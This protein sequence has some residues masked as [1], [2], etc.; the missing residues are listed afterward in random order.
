MKIFAL[1]PLFLV[2]S[3]QESL[4]GRPVIG[5]TV[6]D[7]A[8]T[9]GTNTTPT[10]PTAQISTNLH[11]RCQ[12]AYRCFF[13]GMPA[14]QQDASGLESYVGNRIGVSNYKDPG[15]CAP[16]AAAMVLSAVVGERDS[17]TK[18]NNA[19][20]ENLPSR[21]WYETVYQIG[22]DSY[23]NFYY[24]GTD[25]YNI[26]YSFGKYFERTVATKS[27]SLSWGT[28]WAQDANVTNQDI[29]NLIKSKKPALYIGV[30]ALDQQEAYVG[31]RRKI[32]Y[33][34]NGPGHALV[35]K[36]FDGDRLHIQDPWGMDHFARLQNENFATYSNGS[37][38]VNAVFTD[39]SNS[40]GSFMGT[41]GTNHKIALD[42]VMALSL[43]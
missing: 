21:S 39:L 38:Q 37:T 14:Y 34:V 36:G 20:L 5:N 1:L 32:W 42:E 8:G 40:Q 19:F 18:L 26:Y 13:A 15:L 6:G 3:C 9:E 25:P 22:L 16:T 35:I 29:I 12:S 33:E 27:I 28:S 11:A 31:G 30:D 4:R 24:G 23:T 17:R 41:N 43:D 10:A 2:I 7:P